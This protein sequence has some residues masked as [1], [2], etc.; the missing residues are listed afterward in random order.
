MTN[1]QRK[2]GFFGKSLWVINGLLFIGA[3]LLFRNY[4]P[5]IDTY[6]YYDSVDVILSKAFIATIL[7][8]V[9]GI[10]LMIFNL[11]QLV[12]LGRHYRSLFIILLSSV[13]FLIFIGI[14]FFLLG[15]LGFFETFNIRFVMP[16]RGYH[17][18]F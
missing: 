5:A 10:I 1:Q 16:F 18:P 12:K 3:F 4:P 13:T 9:V 17:P 8:Y 14:T 2:T 7:L 11:I 15:N 6:N